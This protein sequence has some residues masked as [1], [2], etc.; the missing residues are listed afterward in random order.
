MAKKKKNRS[1]SSQVRRPIMPQVLVPQCSH[2]GEP[3]NVG[4]YQI[5]AGGTRYLQPEDLDRADIV[6][7]LGEGIPARLG[8]RVQV[9]ACPWGDMQP[10]PAGFE[11]LIRMQVI[12]E[13]AAGKK[14]LVYC[15]G[16]HGRT[17]TF[18]ASLIS[19]LEPETK[20]PIAAVRN[21]HCYKAV[22]S[23]EQAEFVFRLRGA[24][25]PE[26]YQ[27]E[28]APRVFVNQFAFGARP[29][30]PVRRTLFGDD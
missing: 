23:R 3:V 21:R 12:P 10:P 6:I 7:P 22:E 18:L 16:S 8:Q 9:L 25:L 28:F 26:K 4:P 29:A 27:R 5:L 14:I 15:I 30:Q 13:L 11:Q 24:E 17:G 1:D 20:D 19:V 2:R